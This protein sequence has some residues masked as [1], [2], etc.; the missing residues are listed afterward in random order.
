MRHYFLRTAPVSDPEQIPLVGVKVRTE[1]AAFI[2]DLDDPEEE[3]I[4]YMV[5]QGDLYEALQNAD[6]A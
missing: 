1:G 3:A 4:R 6:A 2:L 5:R